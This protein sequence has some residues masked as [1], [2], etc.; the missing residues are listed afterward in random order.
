MMN[1]IASMTGA[2]VA[3]II[4][5]PICTIQTVYQ[6]QTNLNKPTSVVDC[7][8]QIKSSGYKN[9]YKSSTPA[10][11]SQIVSNGSKYTIYNIIKNYRQNDTK[12]IKNN[13]I[14]GMVGGMLSVIFTQPLD[15][16]KT[17]MQKYNTIVKSDFNPKNIY[18]GWK[19]AISKNLMLGALLFPINDFIGSYTSIPTAAILTSIVITPIIHPI[20]L[21]KRRAMV[22]QPLWLGWNPRPYYR[23]I[24]LNLLR[25]V[26][27]F[28]ITMV[29]TKKI[30][31]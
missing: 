14:N 9:F 15:N 18:G 8:K 31:Q 21:L 2:A 1:L 30:L 20:D 23:G 29:I 22:N 16:I 7:F 12:D 4:V 5:L 27:H 3:E 25:C 13:C 6:T 24:H 19:Q 26:P 28:M 11:L 17:K 10:I